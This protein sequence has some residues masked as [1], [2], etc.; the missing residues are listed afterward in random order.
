MAEHGVKSNMN[1]GLAEDGVADRSKPLRGMVLCC[2][3]I[4]ADQRVRI[5]SF[6]RPCTGK[7]HGED[8]LTFAVIDFVG[9]ASGGHGSSARL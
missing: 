6:T 9:E 2:T 5:T 4:E 8:R 7:L 3:S 1:Y